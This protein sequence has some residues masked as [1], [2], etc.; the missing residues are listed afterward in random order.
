MRRTAE[1]AEAW[2]YYLG[3]WGGVTR[4]GKYTMSAEGYFKSTIVNFKVCF[5]QSFSPDNEALIVSY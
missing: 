2:N 5:S 3:E 1:R 4:I